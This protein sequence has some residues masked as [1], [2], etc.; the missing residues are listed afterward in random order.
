MSSAP[1]DLD[2]P[3]PLTIRQAPALKQMILEALQQ[4]PSLSLR[5]PKAANVD[6]SFVQLVEAARIYA[7]RNGGT[8]SLAAPAD[9]DLL[10]LVQA[11]GLGP[12]AQAFWRCEATQP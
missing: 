11:A 3:P 5:L 1:A 2:I 7:A 6:L 4:H 10:G 12:E 8:L 9:D